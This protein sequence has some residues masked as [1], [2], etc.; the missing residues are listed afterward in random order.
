M[1]TCP[2]CNAQLAET[3]TACPVCGFKLIGQTQ[4]FKP[5]TMNPTPNMASPQLLSEATLSIVKGPQVGNVF[6]LSTD[7]LTIGRSPQC[8]IFLN[9]MT[10]SRMHATMRRT[11]A[12]YEIV[13]ADS[14][15]GLWVNNLNVKDAVLKD[16]DVIQIG[17]FCLVYQATP[18]M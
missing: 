9:D 3:D 13:D 5:I 4:A 16:G 6:R 17:T 8:D 15:N 18:Q 12:G 11:P 2:V 7:T 1:A 14:F 10:V